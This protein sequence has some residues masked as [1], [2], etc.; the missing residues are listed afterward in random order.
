MILP[1]EPTFG[2]PRGR[3][4]AAE[5]STGIIVPRDRWGFR[6]NRSG[7]WATAAV[8]AIEVDRFQAGL[9]DALRIAGSRVAE[10]QPA[11][12]SCAGQKESHD[13]TTR[14]TI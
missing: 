1:G 3:G 14:T 10:F 11:E 4:G 12:S 5:V 13:S 2:R 9:M 8:S 6:S 7:V